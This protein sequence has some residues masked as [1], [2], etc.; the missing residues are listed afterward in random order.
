[1]KKTE[2]YKALTLEERCDLLKKTCP[3][4]EDSFPSD[5]ETGYRRLEEWKKQLPFSQTALFYQRLR[6]EN[7]SEEDFLYLLSEPVEAL[8]E[9]SQAEPLWL[10]SLS[11]IITHS[12]ADHSL[13]HLS[14]AVEDGFYQKC[15]PVLLII[16]PFIS[17]YLERF[18]K[19]IE[20]LSATYQANLP[21]DPTT[22]I[23][24]YSGNLFALIT[25]P[26]MRVVTLEL[27]ISRLLGNLQG[28]SS[29]TRFQDFLNQMQTPAKFHKLI[30]DYP[31][32][33]RLLILILDN[34]LNFG[35]EFLSHLCADWPLILE[36]FSP[37]K[38]VGKLVRWESGAG[39][40]H[41]EGRSV[42]KLGFESG[43]K[44][45]Y[46]PRSLAIDQ[47]F[48]KLLEWINE[49]IQIY[50]GEN[51]LLFKTI[52]VL[53]RDNYGWVEFIEP[54][55]CSSA[56]QIEHFYQ[57]QGGYL[58]LL[59]LLEATDFHQQN[60]IACGEHPVLI[61][62]ETLFQPHLKD[63]GE[64]APEK[65][66]LESLS[67]SVLR[68]ALLPE[69]RYGGKE[70]TGV[71]VS[72]LGGPGGQMSPQPVPILEGLGTDQMR[73]VCK[74]VEI[75]GSAN[76]PKLHGAPV[77]AGLYLE[78]FKLGFINLYELL[79]F[80]KT[81]LIAEPL[82]QFKKNQVRIILRPTYFYNKLLRESWH[83]DWLQNALERDRLFDR[84]WVVTQV[85]PYM[86]QFISLERRDLL[87]GDI[88]YFYT[89][90]DSVAIYDS[91]DNEVVPNFFAASGFRAV[92]Q[93]LEQLSPQDLKK[94]LSF[95]EASFAGL[96][97][98]G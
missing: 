51:S 88:P 43:F 96:A 49:H 68:V 80:Y 97:L 93:R 70:T 69:R 32:L 24:I 40:N 92:Q 63:S 22:L 3:Q 62:L 90:A 6:S 46:K 23:E 36:E 71:N 77:D 59:Y 29:E 72:G 94:Q 12:S 81:A 74:K 60:L 20:E 34:W 33:A 16:K 28:E 31:V 84:L 78:Q 57:R 8:E 79:S 48:Q 11:E 89:R 25:P 26:L 47:H 82:A 35:L 2:L 14:V 19:G 52:K 21:F 39:D 85:E 66:A 5:F 53:N 55:E 18:S 50:Y 4:G 76:M 91:H 9:R 45:I 38:L 67:H 30:Y 54:T 75:A 64:L 13:S 86:A 95:I 98:G 37:G 1:M 87:A 27:H 61:D 41:K 73:V 10:A 15:N 44:L 83:P 7:L 58:A 17:E 42:L 56:Q 65:V